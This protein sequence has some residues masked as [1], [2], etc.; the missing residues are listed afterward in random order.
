M[1]N[2]F[3]PLK[4]GGLTLEDEE[5]IKEIQT[6]I[7]VDFRGWVEENRKNKLDQ[8]KLDSIFSADV[9]LGSKAK[10]LGL[11]DDFGDITTVVKQK[12]PDV[13]K[14]VNFSKQSGW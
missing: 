3:D 1:A 10:E 6:N 11:I 12:H 8:S 13:K 2:R 14:I 5:Y 4:E 7:F 9:F